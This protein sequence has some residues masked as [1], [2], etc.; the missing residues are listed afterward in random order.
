MKQEPTLRIV[1]KCQCAGCL[2][3]F[4]GDSLFDQHR[5]S[6][7]KGVAGSVRRCMTTEEMEAG[8]LVWE[9][10]LVNV[11]HENKRSREK[12]QVWY[13]AAGREAMRA[14]FAKVDNTYGTS[15]HTHLTGNLE[16]DL[17]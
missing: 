5:I 17:A 2:K 9:Y 10:C 1:R 3:Y 4:A 11:R 15:I 13:D 16:F 6:V 14:A 8:G 7:K 12:Q